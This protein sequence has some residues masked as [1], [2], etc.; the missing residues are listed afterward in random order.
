MGV[1][2]VGLVLYIVT[3]VVSEGIKNRTDHMVN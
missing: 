2:I 1:S 3:V